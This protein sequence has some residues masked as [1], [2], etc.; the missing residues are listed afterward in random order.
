MWYING[1]QL[2]N[3][4]VLPLIWHRVPQRSEILL[5][6]AV[7]TITITVT[8]CGIEYLVSICFF[9]SLKLLNV[10]YIYKE[11]EG[12]DRN[13]FMHIIYMV[14]IWCCLDS[15]NDEYR[16]LLLA[17][18]RVLD[19]GLSLLKTVQLWCLD[20]FQHYYIWCNNTCLLLLFVRL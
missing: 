5:N 1:I 10:K 17:S 3:Y 6:V 14:C 16:A 9:L 7:S 12:S 18:E 20:H 19:N 4:C 15:I 11:K 2:Y 8:L 13:Y